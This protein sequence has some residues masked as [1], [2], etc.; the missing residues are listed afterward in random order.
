V[1]GLYA[2]ADRPELAAAFARGG[3][4]VVQ[5]RVKRAG[6]G[7]MLRAARAAAGECRARGVLFIVDDR[8]DVARLAGADGVHLG[9]DDLDV[10][11]ARAVLGP[12]A[13]VGV[14][15]H[16]DAEID[17]A[18]AA[19]ADYLGFG[20]VFATATKE[21]ALP[22]PHGI[23]GLARAVRR[24]GRTPVVAIGG[25][26]VASAAAVA[27]AGAACAAAISELCDASDPEGRA[28]AFAAAFGG[29]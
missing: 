7:E 25:I 1:R 3:A 10:S 17:A 20:P 15:T 16:S 19:G 8:T 22:P 11:A 21:A 26:T 14:S 4:S 9:Q 6:A 13:I 18:L 23:E 24:A 27:A 29:G 12:G 2:I 5:L 28:R